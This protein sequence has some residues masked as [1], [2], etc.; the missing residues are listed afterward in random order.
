MIRTEVKLKLLLREGFNNNNKNKLWNFPSHWFN[1]LT[2]QTSTEA[3]Q[4]TRFTVQINRDWT[5]T[6]IVIISRL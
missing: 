6:V 4:L 3:R 5:T 2:F 1:Q